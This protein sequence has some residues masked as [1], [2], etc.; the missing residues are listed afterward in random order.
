MAASPLYRDPVFDGATDPVLVF[1]RLE[2]SWWMLYTSRR[3]TAP[4]TGVGWV[5]GSDIGVASSND[6]GATWT[7]RGVLELEHDFGR[8][9]FWAPEVLWAR[10]KYHMFVSY[11]RGVP[12]QWAGHARHIHHYTSGDLVS[13]EHGGP[14]PLSSDN[15]I[16]A[17]VHPVPTGG[18]R[19]W[20]KD[21][22]DK[23]S[24]WAVDSVDLEN[25]HGARRVLVT[26]GG[27][28]GPNV[29]RFRGTYWLIVD[30][31]DGQLAYRSED[32]SAWRPAGR[33]LDA[34][35]AAQSSREDDHGPGLHADV[36]VD[37]GRA[38]IIYFTQPQATTSTAGLYPARRSSVLA[39][40]LDVIEGQ[41]VCDRGRDVS[42]ELSDE[43]N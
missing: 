1:S 23:A 5:H 7:Y 16:D 9:T 6:R 24:T 42:L 27:H 28:E 3:A 19:M 32:L 39:A 29:F 8:N 30:S 22:S 35:S 20:Y 25:W 21:E 31:W 40:E 37:H 18:Y 11:V 43:A 10:D 14:L 12:E 41:L 15:V 33:I 38:F 26:A 2:R 4:S 34:A 17:C 36:I 13:W